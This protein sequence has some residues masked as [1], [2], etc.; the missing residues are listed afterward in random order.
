MA[1]EHALPVFRARTGSWE[2]IWFLK[3]DIGCVQ[4]NTSYPSVRSLRTF[5]AIHAHVQLNDLSV[6][7]SLYW[8]ACLVLEDWMLVLT[9]LNCNL[10]F[11][12]AV[13]PEVYISIARSLLHKDFSLNRKH[14]SSWSKDWLHS[15]N[16]APPFSSLR[17]DS[18]TPQNLPLCGWSPKLVPRP[19]ATD[20]Y[21]LKNMPVAKGMSTKQAGSLQGWHN[22]S[23]RLQVTYLLAFKRAGAG[24]TRINIEV[25]SILPACWNFIPRERSVSTALG[26]W[27]TKS[28]TRNT[29]NKRH[30]KQHGKTNA[31]P[32]K[33]YRA[34]G[35]SC[36]VLRLRQSL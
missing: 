12:M 3:H 28:N 18:D 19:L 23:L 1:H 6:S 7:L 29:N 5:S 36:C 11:G 16:G 15:A 24:A 14:Y 21:R 20:S 22:I 34:I 32:S 30:R 35:E 13:V 4:W 25:W 27:C 26:L 8:V 10:S 33:S 17:G 31:L 2:N 9:S